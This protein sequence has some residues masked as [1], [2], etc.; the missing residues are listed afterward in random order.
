MASFPLDAPDVQPL[1]LSLAA[2]VRLVHL[3]WAHQVGWCITLHR[4]TYMHNHVLNAGMRDAGILNDSF[5]RA[6]TEKDADAPFPFNVRAFD[7]FNCVHRHTPL[8]PTPLAFLL[9]S[10]NFP[11]TNKAAI[12]ARSE[13]HFGGKVRY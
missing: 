5:D 10:T 9:V 11:R 12:G 13:R 8:S 6:F 7:T 4:C 1:V 2:D 3:N